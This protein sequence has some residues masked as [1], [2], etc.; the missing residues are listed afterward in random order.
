[1]SQ[2]FTGPKMPALPKTPAVPTV[3]EATAAQ[4]Q[5]EIMRRRRGRASTLLTGDKGLTSQA[6]TAS[7][8]LLGQ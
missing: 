6:P 3:N 4:N 8:T 7:K 5:D 1:M 2:V